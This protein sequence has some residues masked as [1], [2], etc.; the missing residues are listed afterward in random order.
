MEARVCFRK[1]E[2]P[3]ASAQARQSMLAISHAGPW[4]PGQACVGFADMP[5]YR[6]A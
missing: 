3:G 6:A 4:P 5:E 2:K 1:G